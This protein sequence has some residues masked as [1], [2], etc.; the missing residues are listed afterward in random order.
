[1][2]ELLKAQIKK[3]Q[4]LRIDDSGPNTV[5]LYEYVIS[6]TVSIGS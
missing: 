2:H 4:N 1:M 3:K 6:S 5:G